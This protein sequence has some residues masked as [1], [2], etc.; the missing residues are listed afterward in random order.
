MNSRVTAPKSFANLRAVAGLT[1]IKRA[2][3]G[4]LHEYRDKVD[5]LA[6]RGGWHVQF[7]T[8]CDS[9]RRAVL[10]IRKE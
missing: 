8:W 7:A 2:G 6:Q 1:L 5:P 4:H 9:G 10:P 3:S